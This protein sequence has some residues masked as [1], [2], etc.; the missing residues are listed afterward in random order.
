M[1]EEYGFN[2]EF[3]NTMIWDYSTLKFFNRLI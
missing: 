2:K 3:I 1:K